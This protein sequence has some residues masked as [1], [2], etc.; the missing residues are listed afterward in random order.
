MGWRETTRSHR[1]GAGK[2]GIP[3]CCLLRDFHFSTTRSALAARRRM[4]PACRPPTSSWCV[5]FATP[6]IIACAWS[7]VLASAASNP[8]SSLPDHRSHRAQVAPSISAARTARTHR[9]FPCPSSSAKTPPAIEQQVVAL[10]QQLPTFGARRLIRDFDRPLSHRALE[11]IWRAHGLLHPRRR[12][13]QRKHKTGLTSR[14]AD[15]C[16]SRSP[17]IPKTSTTSPHH[18]PQAQALDLPQVQ[19]PPRD[20]RSGWFWWAFAQHRSAAASSVFA[21]R[22][23]HTSSVAESPYA[24][25]SGTPITARSSSAATIARAAAPASPPP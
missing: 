19:Y 11:R 10:R 18:W 12:K 6:T 9:R 16:F 23:Q 17:P 24:T 4:P 7:T 22:I 13:Y 21:A 3:R 15:A 20:V 2:V 5:T 25:R 14:P 8:R 1:R